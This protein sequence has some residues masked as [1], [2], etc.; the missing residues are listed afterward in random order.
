MLWSGSFLP[1]FKATNLGSF[2]LVILP[3]NISAMTGPV[4]RNSP[5]LKPSRF[6][7]GTVPPMMA[8]NC[9]MPSLSRSAPGTGASDAPNVTVLARI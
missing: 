6:T 2:H 8:G 3:M 7:T 4:M 5:G 1:G 9:T